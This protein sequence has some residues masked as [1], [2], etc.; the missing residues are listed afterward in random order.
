MEATR[1]ADQR[2]QA[3]REALARRAAQAVPTYSR[4]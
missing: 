1:A 3:I 2:A 4:E